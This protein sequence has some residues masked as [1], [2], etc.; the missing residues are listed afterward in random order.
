MGTGDNL[1]GRTSTAPRFRVFSYQKE[2]AC[3]SASSP[4]K[5][6]EVVMTEAEK[7][8][9]RRINLDASSPLH[10]DDPKTNENLMK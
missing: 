1:S 9:K 8:A 3:T 6:A 7:L 5:P 2:T 4:A 10:W